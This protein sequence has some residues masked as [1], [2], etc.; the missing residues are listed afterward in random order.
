MAIA[1]DR[2]D[3]LV[4]LGAGY[5]VALSGCETNPETGRRQ[6]ILVSD[7]Q[8]MQ[9]SDSAW[10]QIKQRETFVTGSPVNKQVDRIGTEIVDASGVNDRNWEF[11]VIESDQVNAFVL[12][13]GQVAFYT[14][15]L[16]IMDNDD[17]IATV[18]GHEVG[19]VA[20]NHS[21]ERASQQILAGVGL[22]AATIVAASS[23][24]RHA[25]AIAAALGAGVTFGIIL[26]YSRKHELEADRLG[27]RY[28]A[29][30]GYEPDEALRFWD[31]MSKK[32]GNTIEF[33]STH[34]SDRTRIAAMRNEISRL[35]A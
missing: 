2:R 26:P 10:N 4:G 30:A 9:M 22:T 14:G 19:H 6:L 25:G 7:R 34:P 28:M 21:A 3:L 32:G 33:M 20:G 24:R 18:M 8:L 5:V 16:D 23:D 12:P 17:Q 11:A 15:I 35:G 27:V 29:G 31:T 13:G 1:M